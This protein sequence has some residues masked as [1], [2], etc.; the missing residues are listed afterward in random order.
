MTHIQ[1]PGNKTS[2]EKKARVLLLLCVV[3]LSFIQ[4]YAQLKHEF[5]CPGIMSLLQLGWRHKKDGITEYTFLDDNNV[6]NLTCHNAGMENT[7]SQTN[8]S[9]FPFIIVSAT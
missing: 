6:I 3:L 4:A 2:K 8:S 7:L 1:Y 9:L 5:Y